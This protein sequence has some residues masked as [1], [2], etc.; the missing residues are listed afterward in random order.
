MKRLKNTPW[1]VCLCLLF[2]YVIFGST[3]LA[4]EYNIPHITGGDSKWTDE[5]VIDN[6]GD[7]TEDFW[8]V[9]YN[10]GGGEGLRRKFTIP[11][12]E[13]MTIR[14]KDYAANAQCGAVITDN[15]VT[16]LNGVV[17][18][19]FR[20]RYTSPTDG[21]AEF[22]LSPMNKSQLAF[23]FS[24]NDA[25]D[26]KGL[27]VMNTDPTTAANTVFY[28]I[29]NNG[30]LSQPVVVPINPNQKLVGYHDAWFPTIPLAD[31]QSII[32]SSVSASLCGICISHSSDFSQMLFTTAGDATRF[33]ETNIN[34]RFMVDSKLLEGN[35]VFNITWPVGDIWVYSY[36][37]NRLSGVT[38]A[39][40]GYRINGVNGFGE[41][42]IRAEYLPTTGQFQVVD[43]SLVESPGTTFRREYFFN[44]DAP[45][46][47]CDYWSITGGTVDF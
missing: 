13:T 21:V 14:L 19:R 42:L 9:L 18:L 7:A 10:T 32:V 12:L 31:I 46:T 26:W 28:A 39:E 34:T 47:E 24:E 30:T 15:T 3:A 43:T 22:A 5:L 40:T 44:L 35:W 33:R 45:S 36:N 27:A 2:C 1:I 25:M 8:V 20:L 41:A 29:Y 37:F 4:M 6:M 11:A 38:N 16:P 23:N 17:Y